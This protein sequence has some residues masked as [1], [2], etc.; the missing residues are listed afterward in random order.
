[1]PPAARITATAR[2]ASV[3]GAL[4]VFEYPYKVEGGL[5][6]IQ[7]GVN[8]DSGSLPRLSWERNHRAPP[9]YTLGAWFGPAL[10]TGLLPFAKPPNIPLPRNTRV[11]GTFSAARARRIPAA[12]RH[13]NFARANLCP[14]ASE[15]WSSLQALNH[16]VTLGWFHPRLHGWGS[17]FMVAIVLIT[18]CKFSSRRLQVFRAELTWIVGVFLLLMD[19]GMASPTGACASIK[20]HMWDWELRFHSQAECPFWAGAS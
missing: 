1:V 17:N 2:A 12:V 11:G 19:S 10:A 20:M 16:D 18:W 7:A 15:A 3:A 8:A 4:A 5:V 13:R 6:T 9:D 14:S